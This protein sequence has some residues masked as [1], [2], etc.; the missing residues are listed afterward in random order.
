MADQKPSRLAGDA[1]ATLQALLAHQRASLVRKVDGLTSEQ[2]AWSP[3]LSGTSLLW[4]VGHMADAEQTWVVGRF[5]GRPVDLPGG[6]TTALSDDLAASVRA[7]RATWTVVDTIVAEATG[8]DDPCR[9]DDTE[10][11]VNLV[12]VL[13]HLVEETARHAGHAD[14]LHEMLDGATG[15]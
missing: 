9:G 6:V 12:W 15:R 13:S 10:P 8:P 14:I 7:Y 5:D 1:I 11:P 3:V 4:L 2:A